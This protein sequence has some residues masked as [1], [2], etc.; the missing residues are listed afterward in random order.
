MIIGDFVIDT[1]SAIG[2]S[3]QI[4]LFKNSVPS[5]SLR[6]AHDEISRLDQVASS[7]RADSELSELNFSSDRTVR[8]SD[9]MFE[10][11]EVYRWAFRA[12]RGVIDATV[13]RQLIDVFAD[14]NPNIKGI[15][16]A[17]PTAAHST[18]ADIT[19]DATNKLIN[20]TPGVILDF[21]GLAK[22]WL[23]DRI[24]S[25]V[26]EL[27]DG[28][29]L[30]SLGGDIS[31]GGISP[32]G[33]WR[34][35]VTDNFGLEADAPGTIIS[36]KSG[37]IATSS[38]RTRSIKNRFGI[39]TEHIVGR[40]GSI[41]SS[42]YVTATAAAPNALLANFFTLSSLLAGNSALSVIASYSAPALIRTDDGTTIRIGGWPNDDRFS[43][44]PNTDMATLL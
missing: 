24:L 8:V 13:G 37:G 16:D 10:L 22:A 26:L 43:S 32:V 33:G 19:L 21:G 3:C 18:F 35:N 14:R 40:N 28:G 15:C 29:A 11:L 2:T 39:E 30:V 41:V 34:V 5:A 4:I 42:P 9:P 7:Y 44:V 38:R 6:L 20:R 31:T 23:A 27:G 17:N 1:F 36:V 12:S 25:Q